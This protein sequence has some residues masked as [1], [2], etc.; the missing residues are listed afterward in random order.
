MR[1]NGVKTGRI[2]IKLFM[3]IFIRK[4]FSNP[5]K[6]F[7]SETLQFELPKNLLICFKGTLA[8]LLLDTTK[9]SRSCLLLLNLKQRVSPQLLKLQIFEN[10]LNPPKT[11]CRHQK[12]SAAIQ[13]HPPKNIC[14]YPKPTIT[15]QGHRNQ[16]ESTQSQL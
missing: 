13:N 8:S 4:N 12:P 6:V 14:N 11:I 7:L 10:H 3:S 15:A 5:T 2:Y 9:T 16:P 1:R